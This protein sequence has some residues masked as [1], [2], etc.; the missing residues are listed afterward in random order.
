MGAIPGPI[1]KIMGCHETQLHLGYKLSTVKATNKAWSLETLNEHIKM[2]QEI[3]T[4]LA[5]HALFWKKGLKVTK[6]WKVLQ[7]MIKDQ[8]N[9]TEKKVQPE[10]QVMN[11]THQ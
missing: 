2:Q 6:Q 7:V 4:E 1:A 9:K 5:K 8:C 3:T 11:P 10:Y